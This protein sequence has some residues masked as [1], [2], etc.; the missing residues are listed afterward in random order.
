MK[1]MK[2]PILSASL[3]VVAS[4]ALVHT[5]D[6]TLL[7]GWHDFDGTNASQTPPDDFYPGFET[8][9]VRALGGGSSASG[10]DT[11]EFPNSF[12][13][14]SSF[15]TGS[16]GN[17]G[18]LIGNKDNNIIVTV[19]NNS[20]QRWNLQNLY[21][22]AI[23]QTATTEIRLFTGT[24]LVG[25]LTGIS[26]ST[27]PN[28]NYSDLSFSLSGITLFEGSALQFQ[29]IGSNPNTQL[30]ANY[31]MDNIALTGTMVVIPEPG[32]SLAIGLLLASG[33]VL[34]TRPRRK[35]SMVEA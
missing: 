26:T 25:P 18:Y 14:N 2:S 13:G 11:N 20:G 27:D 24:G 12:Y 1:P 31:F 17:D 16:D 34:R 35:L 15:Q 33:L 7:V 10:G 30:D 19:E 23:V 3:A 8:S 21:F 28:A 6:A 29:F 22:D 32:S 4:F 9:A 5:S